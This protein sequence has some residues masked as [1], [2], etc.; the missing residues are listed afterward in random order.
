MVYHYFG[1]KDEIFT[2]LV[3]RALESRIQ[4]VSYAL[5]QPGS[6]LDKINWLTRTILKSG[7]EDSTYYFLIVLQSFTSDAIPE[8][9]KALI[10]ALPPSI[11]DFDTLIREGQNEGLIIEGK[12]VLLGA[13]YFS[14][15]QGLVIAGVEG[16]GS[17]SDMDENLILRLLK[18]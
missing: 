14:L 6:A 5:Q 4:V 2:E 12:P 10:A 9:V 3:K 7:G 13:L 11:K 1:S 17:M 8:E 15:I 18:K 16:F